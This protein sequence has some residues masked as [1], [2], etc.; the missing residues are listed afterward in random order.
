MPDHL[1][2]ESDIVFSLN[3][4]TLN[5][6][7]ENADGMLGDLLFEMLYVQDIS[8]LKDHDI[9][10]YPSMNS[11]YLNHEIIGQRFN[12]SAGKLYFDKATLFT[13]AFNRSTKY[14]IVI[15]FY[16]AEVNKT[17][18]YTLYGCTPGTFELVGRDND[19]MVA[20][21]SYRPYRFI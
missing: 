9:D 14:R 15:N 21:V 7:E 16:E 5:I 11:N 10:E 4:A 6:Y 3:D 17:E 2:C 8:L 1:T 20:R 13:S 18:T 19:L 12:F